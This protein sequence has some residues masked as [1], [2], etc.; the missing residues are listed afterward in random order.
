MSEMSAFDFVSILEAMVYL[1]DYSKRAFW[2][3][4]VHHP[5]STM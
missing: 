5:I 2:H 3:F 4:Q 1:W